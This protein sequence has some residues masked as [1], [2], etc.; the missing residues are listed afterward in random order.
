MKKISKLGG[1]LKDWLAQTFPA[2]DVG[3]LTVGAD[4]Q[5]LEDR[6]LYSAS[7]IPVDPGDAVIAEMPDMFDAG[8]H[9]SIDQ[10][11]DFLAA[12]MDDVYQL[13]AGTA[14]LQTSTQRGEEARPLTTLTKTLTAFD[15]LA[16]AK[17]PTRTVQERR[18]PR[19]N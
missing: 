8:G 4:L 1:R 19:T 5:T 14:D 17:T 16:I 3:Q 11:F 13:D 7:P 10:Q 9:D 18:R 15:P 12:S 6:V 2:P